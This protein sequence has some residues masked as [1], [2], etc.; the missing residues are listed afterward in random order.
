MLPNHTACP[1]LA[2]TE[3]VAKHRDRL[4]TT[5]WAHQFPLEISFNARFSSA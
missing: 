1:A 5:G 4:A 2:D 3:A